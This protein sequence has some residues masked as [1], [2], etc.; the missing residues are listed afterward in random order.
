MYNRPTHLDINLNALKH[1]FEY[2]KKVSNKEIFAVVKAN[3]YGHGMIGISKFFD[4]LNCAYLCVS[5]LDEALRLRRKGVS[6]PILVLGYTQLS[7]QV[8]NV[9]SENNISLTI[10]SMEW[11]SELISYDTSTL[12]INYHIEVDTGMNRLGFKDINELVSLINLGKENQIYFEGIYTHF[13]SSD[14]QDGSMENQFS[15]FESILK[16]LDYNFKWVHTSNSDAVFNLKDTVSNAIRPGLALYGYS[17]VKTDL[18]PIMHFY[19][20]ITQKK[21]L[22]KN[23]TVSYGATFTA[24]EDMWIGIVPVGYADG[25]PLGL[26]NN[27]SVYIQDKSCPLIGKICMDQLM[28]KIPENLE[29]NDVTISGLTSNFETMAKITNTI[30]YEILTCLNIRIHRIFRLDNQIFIEE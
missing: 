10:I 16:L 20:L 11:F 18:I 5:S 23:E 4:T 1:N 25:L 30:T 19:S 21:L 15:K 6:S 8:L 3:A 24:N 13:H 26:S 2:L 22:K 29:T 7:Q 27:F 14:K 28:I 17:S 9:A 12:S